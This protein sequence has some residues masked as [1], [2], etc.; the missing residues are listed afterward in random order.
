MLSFTHTLVSLPLGFYFSQPAVALSLAFLLHLWLDS[1]LHWNIYPQNFK[2]YPYGLVALD[3]TAG[4]L[5]A[6]L[7][8]G[9]RFLTPS[10][11]AA[12]IGG[13]LP[14]ILHGF[15]TL[16]PPTSRRRW[17]QLAHSFFYL[18]E[19]LQ[20]ETPRPLTGLISQVIVITLSFAWLAWYY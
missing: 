14:D 8:T 7:V 5:V 9:E 15:W 6:W 3:V 11:L 18:H 19:H 1:L 12:I 2:R 20:K 17:P 4:L 13:N 16:A 10:L